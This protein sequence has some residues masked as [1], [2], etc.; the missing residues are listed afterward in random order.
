MTTFF[1]WNCQWNTFAP[2]VLTW[3][4]SVPALWTQWKVSA[5]WIWI[6][7][8]CCFGWLQLDIDLRLASHHLPTQPAYSLPLP[9]L[10]RYSPSIE[11]VL[12]RKVDQYEKQ[13][14]GVPTWIMIYRS[15]LGVSL[16]N[17]EWF[18]DQVMTSSRASWGRWV[19]GR[20][21]GG[22]RQACQADE[23]GV[24]RHLKESM[25]ILS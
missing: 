2:A 5:L 20:W 8:I 10:H 11:F 14:S 21:G 1:S 22:C 16:I 23:G 12:H 25:D 9:R 15:C 4:R 13:I 19:C 18:G 7:R 17:T 3:L 24:D 6:P